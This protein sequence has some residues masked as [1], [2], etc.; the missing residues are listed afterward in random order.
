MKYKIEN[1]IEEKIFF[2]YCIVYFYSV[3]HCNTIQYYSI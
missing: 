3:N 2:F 1:L